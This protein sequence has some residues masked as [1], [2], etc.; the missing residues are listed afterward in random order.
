MAFHCHPTSRLT[1]HMPVLHLTSPDLTSSSAKQHTNSEQDEL[2]NW[3]K[4]LRHLV[5]MNTNHS[6]KPLNSRTTI[7]S[8]NGDGS[9]RCLRVHHSGLMGPKFRGND[10]G[11]RRIERRSRCTSRSTR[12]TSVSSLLSLGRTP[13]TASS[14]R[15]SRLPS[16]HALVL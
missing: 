14:S 12:P 6:P 10:T 5:K 11:F 9:P 15:P 7:Q 8:S 1:S 4:L 13:T 3:K 16:A 2:Q